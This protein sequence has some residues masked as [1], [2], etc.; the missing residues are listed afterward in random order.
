MYD[1]NFDWD[2]AEKLMESGGS[3]ATAVQDAGAVDRPHDLEPCKQLLQ[4]QAHDAQVNQIRR[5]GADV[6][7]G[8]WDSASLRLWRSSDFWTAPPEPRPQL[9]VQVGGFLNDFAEIAE[10][11]LLVAV[12]AGLIPTPGEALKLYDFRGQLGQG[13]AT[14]DGPKTPSVGSVQRFEFHTRGCRALGLWRR[15]L[16]EWPQWVGSISKDSL[17]LCH[18]S[19]VSS[20]SSLEK[21]HLVPNPHGLKEVTSL[22]WGDEDVLYSGGTD[23]TVKAWK[24]CESSCEPLWSTSVAVGSWVRKMVVAADSEVGHG[25]GCLVVGHSESVAWLDPR[26]REKVIGKLEG[27]GQAHAAC[28]VG[29]QRLVLALGR[30]LAVLDLRLG[31]EVL[32]DDFQATIVSLEVLSQLPGRINLLAGLKDGMVQVVDVA[33][34]MHLK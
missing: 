17:V 31:H 16:E 27:Y 30:Q 18:S 20:G 21:R 22:C 23:G 14:G 1:P 24:V 33:T 15:S 13:T 11:Q 10:H 5:S 32:A 3:Q 12:S 26:L 4:W 9:E 19:Q 29:A 25:S 2:E 7:T 6:F 34:T 8:C 28:V